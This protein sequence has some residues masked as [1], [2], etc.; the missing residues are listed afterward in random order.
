MTPDPKFEAGQLAASRTPIAEVRVERLGVAVETPFAIARETLQTAELALVT[1]ID[2]KGCRGVG[3]CAPFPSLTHDTAASAVVIARELI[4]ELVGCDV[5]EAFRRLRERR[6][7]VTR[8]SIT[9]FVGVETDI[10]DL[11]ARQLG[12]PLAALWGGRM[13]EAI[14][15]DI[16]LPIMPAAG[17]AAFW[18]RFQGYGF[19]TV[20][21]K[22]GGQVDE[23]LARIL[24]IKKLVSPQVMLTLDGNQG[25][26]V[27]RAKRLATECLR[28]GVRP[29]FFEQ[30]LPENS[31]KAH[32]ELAA[33]LP[34]PICLDETVRTTADALRVARERTAQ[35]VNI[36]IM[37]SGIEEALRI[38][39]IC[40]AA[41][42]QL[43]IGGMLE[44]EFAMGTS[45]QLAAGTGAF[46]YVDLDTPFFF[47]DR[48]SVDSPWHTPSACLNV[49]QSPGHGMQVGPC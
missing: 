33:D 23:D 18:E 39:H 4:H 10:W 1:C 3:E 32:A 19:N 12:V 38:I 37:K 31:W 46:R 29:L 17:V 45:L 11:F 7:E 20:K 14:E 2:A 49:P 6:A 22:V 15:T 30:P 26:D 42:I 8:L 43:M 13:L 47:C 36:K 35:I 25:Y 21:I 28:H 24:A 9:A 48:L 40:E 44:S 41:G 27:T 5:P 16:T 34:F